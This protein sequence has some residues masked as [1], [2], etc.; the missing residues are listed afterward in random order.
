MNTNNDSAAS[1]GANRPPR[2]ARVSSI[3][4]S[5]AP[6]LYHAAMAYQHA[7]ETGEQTSRDELLK[8]HGASETELDEFIAGFN[9][10]AQAVGWSNAQSQSADTAGALE[11]LD[12]R[13]PTVLGDFRLIRTIGRGGMG[14][15]YEAQQVSLGRRVALKVLPAISASDPRRLQ[16]FQREA[17]AAA[18]LQHDHIV[19][20]YATGCEGA[21]HFYAMQLI[22]GTSLAL[23]YRELVRLRH[24]PQEGENWPA[25]TER[26][27]AELFRLWNENRPLYQRTIASIMRDVALAL[28]YAHQNGI[29]H[30][31]IKPENLLVDDQ[32]RVWV[33]DFGLAQFYSDS[34][35][36]ETGAVLGTLRY[37][38]PEQ[39][40]GEARVL[41]HRTD[42]Y[43][44]GMSFYELLCLEDALRGLTRGD[45]LRQIIHCEPK[46]LRRVDP[47]IPNDLAIIVAKACDKDAS[48]RYVS[49]AELA[50]DLRFFLEGLPIRS[51][52][53]SPIDQSIKWIRRNRQAA[54][55][56]A[57]AV[58]LLIV[59][60]ITCTGLVLRAHARTQAAYLR[61]HEKTLEALRMEEVARDNFLQARGAVD[62]FAHLAAEEL[63]EP[64]NLDLRRRLLETALVYYE[65]FLDSTPVN[66]SQQ[67]ELIA[68]RAHISTLLSELA[69]LDQLIQLTL[70]AK[71]F[72]LPAVSNELRLSPE[73]IQTA[74]SVDATLGSE[75]MQQLVATRNVAPNLRRL[76]LE[77][78]FAENKLLAQLTPAQ[79]QR[80]RQIAL[81]AR[82]CDAFTDAGVPEELGLNER[83]L[84]AI[85][86]E[87][88]ERRDRL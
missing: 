51:S 75:I 35:L 9:F 62:F 22:P 87:Q 70:N 24:A 7:C 61:E 50:D 88:K 34:G 14:V 57:V 71:L 54:Q 83:Q 16:R 84:S 58:S 11:L 39:A 43:S 59:G 15:V 78:L 67:N 19:P 79:L 28:D 3:D 21:H 31:D 68:T 56:A 6:E 30:R 18:L 53:P 69:T 38:S 60:L 47:T 82:G 8:T 41:D 44:L 13:R 74:A 81:Q 37:M 36:T 4:E 76:A 26:L 29:V 12:A 86:I 65:S 80:L 49:A 27:V 42:I 23:I 48:S 32:L 2:A 45:L 52:S 40:S 64:Q 46:N 63:T 66:D 33:T 20:V 25:D 5:I 73:Q 77:K 85:R 55:Y 10:V 17:Q 1:G 72:L